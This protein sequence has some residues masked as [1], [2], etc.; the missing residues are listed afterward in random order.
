MKID[1]FDEYAGAECEFC[2]IWIQM[3]GDWEC[4][5]CGQNTCDHCG[6][7]DYVEQIFLCP[8]CFSKGPKA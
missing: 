1:M 4:E 2:G 6:K 8:E 3:T 7:F 5:E